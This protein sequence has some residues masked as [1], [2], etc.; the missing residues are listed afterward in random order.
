MFF[1]EKIDAIF[2]KIKKSDRFCDDEKLQLDRGDLPA[3][4]LAAAVVFLPVILILVLI[5]VWAY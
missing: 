3:M 4:F 2:G 5:L 1:K